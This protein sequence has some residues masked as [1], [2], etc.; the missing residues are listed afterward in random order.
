M[1][2]QNI[3]LAKFNFNTDDVVKGAAVIKTAMDEIKEQQTQLRKDG[4]TSSVEFVQN[5]ANLKTLSG[6]YNKHIKALSNVQKAAQKTAIR[7]TLL[8]KVL[9]AQVDNIEDAREQNKLL[10]DLRNTASVTT[11]KGRQQL[12]QLNE[13]LNSNNELIA[14]NVDNYTKQK[15]N[16]GNYTESIID[17]YNALEEQKKQLEANTTA[18]EKVRDEQEKGSESWSFYNNQIQQNNTQIN[19]LITSMGGLGDETKA[20]A[21]FTKLLSGDIAGLAEDAKAAGGAGKLMSKSLKGVAK[22]TWG[23]IKASLAFLATPV[24]AILLVIA[25]AFLLIKNAM[26]RSEEATN[27][28]KR[29]FAPLQGILDAVLG[30]LEPLGEFLIDG[31]V[32]GMELAEE[33]IYKAIDAFADIA[34]FLGFDKIA[35]SARDFNK[36]IQQGAKDAVALADAEARLV[37]Q[38]REARLLQLEYQKD[39]EKLRQIRDDDKLQISERIAANEQ[40]GAVL[41]QQ[42]QDELRIAQTALEVANLRMKAE[43][44]SAATLDAQ[45]AALEQIADIEERITGQRSEQLTNRNA[46]EKEAEEKR[47]AAIDKRIEKMKQELDLYISQ[48]GIK[49]QTLAQELEQE[50]KYSA[51]RLAIFKAEFDAKKSTELE[52]QKQV[53]DLRNELAAKEAQLAVDEGLRSVELFRE[54]LEREREAAEFLSAEVVAR[55]KR[56]NNALFEV[57]RAQH[58]LALEQG[59]IDQ[60]EYDLAIR[61]AKE[62]NRLANKELDAEREE[63]EKAEAL[64]LRAIEFEEEIERLTEENA[65]K[66]EI[67]AAQQ[68]EQKALDLAKLEE[69]F[70]KELISEQLYE[71][72]RKQ[73]DARSKKQELD[74]DKILA[75]QKLQVATGLLGAA[76]QVIDQESKAGKAIA[77]G[78][79][80]INTFQGIT[81]GV[82]LGYPAAIPAVAFAAA[83]GFAAVKNIVKTE[84]PSADGG[85]N[86]GGGASAPTGLGG[87]N[88]GG[89]ANLTAIASSGNAAVQGQIEQ[90]SNS[91]NIAEEV[92]RAAE[93]GTRRGAER[94]ATDGMTNLSSNRRIQE[95]STF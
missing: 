22:A 11:E 3:D 15:L 64:E 40:L 60:N 90:A 57:E 73:I 33:A 1:D 79:A 62:A 53:T 65:A 58:E 93:E 82:K 95:Q 32:L 6:E 78:Q 88:L 89:A 74:R 52:Y 42:L 69:D 68:A 66:H 9:G 56:E 59:V 80:A 55:K 10:N 67:L 4:K 16:I 43:G 92:G 45:A 46:L 71:A 19:V 5:Q 44:E 48:Q 86:V 31:I 29:A 77:L 24:G 36:E 84:V 28:L 75:Q 7:E 8:N 61:E 50:R 94:G 12:K 23:V 47:Q 63:V 41:E 51:D 72:R 39:A 25:G 30:L 27:K 2:E 37:K 76:S 87:V 83:T 91:Q 81:A 18:L 85:G 49:A 26:N 14:E 54:N 20:T 35:A 70:K 34:D 17:A 13:Q 38:Q 21:T